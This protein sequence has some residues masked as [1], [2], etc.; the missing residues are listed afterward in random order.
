MN[1]AS[2]GATSFAGS[3]WRQDK[4]LATRARFSTAFRDR[5]LEENSSAAHESGGQEFESVRRFGT[6]PLN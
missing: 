6:G 5:L 4:A 3:T 2:I 1:R